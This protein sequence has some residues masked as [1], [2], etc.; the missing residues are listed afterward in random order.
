MA[1]EVPMAVIRRGVRRGVV[2]NVLSIRQCLRRFG[3]AGG[4]KKDL[5]PRRAAR[6]IKVLLAIYIVP[7][8]SLTTVLTGLGSAMSPADSY[9]P[10]LSCYY[11]WTASPLSRSIFI[12]RPHGDAALTQPGGELRMHV[13]QVSKYKFS[14]RNRN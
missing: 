2:L 9:S 11:R 5:Y 6:W 13:G 7:S 14:G 3:F 10:L 8:P 12:P 4:N 1:D